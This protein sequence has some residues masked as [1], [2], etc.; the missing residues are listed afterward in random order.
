MDR[1]HSRS[2]GPIASRNLRSH[3]PLITKL[4]RFI[5]LSD[6]DVRLLQSLCSRQTRV[7]LGANLVDEGSAPKQ[8]F[9]IAWGLAC[10]YRIMPDGR[11]QI[12]TF[13]LPGDLCDFDV[14]LLDEVDHSIATL[15]PTWF[16]S[17][18]RDRVLEIIQDHPRIA[19]ALWRSAMQEAAMLRE[20]V[21]MLGRGNAH[22]RVAYLFCEFFWR[23][24]AIGLVEDHGLRLP[25]TQTDIADALGLS[26]IH[27]NRVLQDL[28]R[29][30]LIRLAHRHL[31]LLDLNRLQTIAQ[32]SPN[33][34]QNTRIPAELELYLE[35]RL[36]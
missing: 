14:F 15:V 36:R 20:R 30:R 4:S 31:D 34:L 1:G 27:V 22:A 8:G 18:E 21:L 17:I 10:R 28:R 7:G 19:V 6:T 13:L 25:L 26:P 12:L 33:Y 23:Y 2:T 32:L 11:R 35:Q 29:D 9:V 3:P 24:S 16:V 5:S